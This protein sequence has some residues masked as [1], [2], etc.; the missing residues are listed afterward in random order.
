MM[1]GKNSLFDKA[2]R[3]GLNPYGIA[4]SVGLFAPPERRNPAPLGLRGFLDLAESIDAAGVELPC[5]LLKGV[6]DAEVDAVCARLHRQERYAILMHGISWGDLDGALNCA[7]RFRFKTIRMHLTAILSGAR[8]AVRHWPELFAANS[9]ALVRFAAQAGEA[10]IGMTLEDHQD[11][12]SG[13]LLELCE[14][15]GPHAGICLDTGN[16]FS[17][18]EDPLDF[19][20][21]VAGRTRHVH[22]KDYRIHW[23]A[24]GYRLARC[25]IGAGA[26]D[27]AGL[28]EILAPQ[29]PLPAS[30][31]PGALSE[32]HIRLLCDDWWEGYP[33]GARA[34]LLSCLRTASARR[35]PDSADW[36]TPWE[37]G[38]S[39]EEIVAYEQQELRQSVAFLTQAPQAR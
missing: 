30:I 19:A 4:Y 38:A 36:R 29:G 11:L 14:R 10:G 12:G 1:R 13:E 6:A 20:R 15:C 37:R 21:A 3:I 23:S 16:P 34:S 25:A 24:E 27:F 8:A 7:R 33:P 2:F 35:A 9:A 26:V 39:P 31:E 28:A 17:V 18:G 5:A 32:R 22:L